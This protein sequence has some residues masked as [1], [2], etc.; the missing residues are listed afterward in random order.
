MGCIRRLDW[1][2]RPINEEQEQSQGWEVELRLAAVSGM[3]HV[4]QGLKASKV[5]AADISLDAAPSFN[6]TP[7]SMPGSILYATTS[8]GVVVALVSGIFPLFF[9]EERP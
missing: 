8:T 2:L 9:T 5:N 6:M 3:S 4:F 1:V 7:S